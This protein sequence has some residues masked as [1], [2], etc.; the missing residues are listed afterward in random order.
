MFKNIAKFEHIVEGKIGHFL[1]D[2]DT[3][4]PAA[5]EMLLQFLKF[6]GQIE[7]NV[8]AQQEAQ[9]AAQKAGEE[10]KVEPITDE[11]V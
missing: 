7:D 8:K 11:A 4:L 6:V 10:T 3:P 1:C 2:S 9:A 5:K